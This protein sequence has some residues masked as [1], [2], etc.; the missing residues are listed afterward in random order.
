MNRVPHCAECDRCQCIDF[1]YKDY[2]CCEENDTMWIFGRLGV[3]HPPKTSPKWCP[4][5]IN[6]SKYQ[7]NENYSD[8]PE[9]PRLEIYKETFGGLENITEQWYKNNE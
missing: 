1:I 8:L 3:D 4:L 6:D 5:R 9:A 7:R 2:Y